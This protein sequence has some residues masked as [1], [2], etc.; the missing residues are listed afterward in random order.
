MRTEAQRQKNREYM[1]TWRSQPKHQIRESENRSRWHAQRKLREY[2]S[3]ADI[4]RCFGC[5]AQDGLIAI[6]RLA[7]LP[8]RFIP[9]RVFWCGEC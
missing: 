4:P 8:S 7:A 3:Q 6:P 1:R 5:G 2:L 9:V